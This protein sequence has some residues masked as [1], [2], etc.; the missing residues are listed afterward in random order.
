[1]IAHTIEQLRIVSNPLLQE[2]IKTQHKLDSAILNKKIMR[3]GRLQ[4]SWT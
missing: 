1:M 3:Q 4:I 2:L